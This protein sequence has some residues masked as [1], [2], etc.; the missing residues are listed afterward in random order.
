MKSIYILILV[1]TILSCK[2]NTEN[3]NTVANSDTISQDLI[4]PLNSL[5]ENNTDHD[6]I[7]SNAVN[8]QSLKK[9]SLPFDFQTYMELC[10]LEEKSECDKRFPFCEATELPTV[11]NLINSKINKNTPS[12]FYWMENGDLS[13]DTYIFKI[14]DENEDYFQKLFL[15]NVKENKIVSSQEIARIIDGESP[16]DADVTEKTFIMDT[17]LTISI[18]NKVYQ[19]KNK[20]SEK[21]KIAQD[22]KIVSLK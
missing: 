13:F 15:I 20:L 6:T 4:T 1:L 21:Y 2:S 14:R 3:T 22:G 7:K 11:T 16:E 9:V 17:D 19:K 10:Y 5:K 18:Y 8:E 12:R